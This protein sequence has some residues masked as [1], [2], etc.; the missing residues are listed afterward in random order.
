MKYQDFVPFAEGMLKSGLPFM[1]E[2]EPGI[3][4]TAGIET[5]C[6]NLGYDLLTTEVAVRSPIDFGGIPAQ[7][8]KPTEKKAAEWDFVPIGDLRRL[9][10]ATKPTVFFLDDYG[11]GSTATQNATTHLIHAR[12]IGENKISDHVRIVAATNRAEDKS[13]VNPIMEHVK[14]RFATIVTGRS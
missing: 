4:K 9:V 12:R 10:N 7:V 11:Q 5:A 6:D 1:I 13:G 2:G 14:S 3:G 8:K